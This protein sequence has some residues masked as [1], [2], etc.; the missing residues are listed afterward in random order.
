MTQQREIPTNTVTVARPRAVA[1][2]RHSALD[3]Q[4]NSIPDQQEQVQ[5]WAKD[6]GIEIIKEF[7]DAGR[8]GLT[9]ED[10]PAFG[11]MMEE[12][13]KTRD[14]FQCVLCLDESRLGRFQD[15]VC[16][17]H[18]KQVLYADGTPPKNDPLYPVY[19]RFERLRSAQYSRELGDKVRMARMRLLQQGY[20]TGGTPPYGLRRLLLDEKGNPLHL[21][22]AGQRK[23][24]EKQ[25]VTLVAGEPAQVAAIRRIFQEF[26]ERGYSPARIAQGLNARR[27]PSPS[28]SR[29]SAVQ[30]RDRLRTGAYAATLIYLWKNRKT[31]KRGKTSDQWVRTPKSSQGIISREL[32]LRAQELLR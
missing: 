27:I 4:K 15:A 16:E 1:Y 8:G 32:F 18:N 23:A 5:K 9:T 19:V 22:E 28:G 2:Y 10:R 25:H 6:H 3:G 29:W 14:D 17:R 21:L 24:I 12:W 20:W 31:A 11:E 26:V 7:V 30:V 13:V